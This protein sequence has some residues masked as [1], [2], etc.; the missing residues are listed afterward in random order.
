[1]HR[2]SDREAQF[3]REAARGLQDKEIAARFGLHPKTVSNTLSSA[4]RKLNVSNRREAVRYLLGND[5]PREA[6]P[7]PP[8][9]DAAQDRNAP[10]PSGEAA[11]G[12]HRAVPQISTWRSRYR[13]PPRIGG[14]LL[15]VILMWTV[16]GA[17][18]LTT[19]FGLFAA[20][21]LAVQPVAERHI[22]SKDTP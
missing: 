6:I 5:Y 16:L 12:D 14:T 10:T 22:S 17:L 19:V 1:M 15:P 18:V 21:H 9:A 11:G 8:A 2:L 13:Y 20:Y 3:L 4:Y 7:I